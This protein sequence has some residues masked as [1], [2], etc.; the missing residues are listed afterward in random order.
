MDK[1]QVKRALDELA[2]AAVPEDIEVWPGVRARV[3]GGRA[4]AW[5]AKIE[6][7]GRRLGGRN[8][9]IQGG[10]AGPPL[11]LGRLGWAGLAVTGLLVLAATAYAAAP[12]INKL[13]MMDEQ[14]RNSEAE[15]L[16]Q[17]LDLSQTLGDVTATVQWA[18]A[19]GQRV[20]VG[21]ALKTADGR[22]FDP[23][24]AT[25]T[26]SSGVGLHSTGGYGVVGHSD[27]LGVSLPPGE[28]ANVV[29][30]D[31]PASAG[32]AASLKLHLSLMAAEYMP[33]SEATPEIHG[34][35][36]QAQPAI[37]LAT[38]G[39]FEFDFEVPVVRAK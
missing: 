15:R 32:Q 25:V 14:F 11:R 36:A 5:V 39:P 37:R 18:Y 2:E 1:L 38:A 27:V 3:E 34:N 20:L 19:D 16:G 26:D 8:P 31:S 4:G 9:I 23:A 21:Y 30:F 10:H 13:L 35:T 22:R 28:S 7:V 33:P 12:V 29:L 17:S 6:Q 24:G